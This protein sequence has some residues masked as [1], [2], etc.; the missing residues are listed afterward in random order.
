M[1]V[2]TWTGAEIS[3]EEDDE[4]GRPHCRQFEAEVDVCSDIIGGGRV[5]GGGEKENYPSCGMV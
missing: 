2:V 4:R 1:R 5:G 3:F